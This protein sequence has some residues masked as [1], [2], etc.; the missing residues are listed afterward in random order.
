MTLEAP[1]PFHALD[2]GAALRALVEGTA[3]EIGEDFFI[4]LV[5]SLSEALRTDGAMV[6]EYLEEKRHLRALA[7]LM[8]GEWVPDYEFDITNTP[9]EAVITESRLLHVPENLLAMYPVDND[10]REAGLVSY[11]GV[12]LQDVDGHIL[13]HM[14]VVDRR[15]MPADPKAIALFRIFAA[16]AAAEMRRLRAEG[17]VRQREEKVRRLLDSAMDAILE[18]DPNLCVTQ[19]NSAAE[20]VFGCEAPDLL[21]RNFLELLSRE[22]GER[23]LHHV[24][25]IDAFPEGLRSTW[26]PG[27]LAA[28]RVG[29]TCFQAEATLSRFEV[30]RRP[31]HT[32][33]LRNVEDRLAAERRIH[34]LEDQ[35]EY[36]REEL[37]ALH[38]FEEIIGRSPALVSVLRDVEQVAETDST[39]L[40]LGETGVGKELIARAIHEASARR[41]KPLVKVN[42]AAVPANLIE[43]EFFG[44]EAGAFTGATRRR[45]GR[46]ALADKGSIFLDEVGELPLDL[47]AK[48]LRVLQEGEFE[49]VGSSITR[50]VDARILA[51][52]NR[53]LGQAVKQGA[54][55]EDLYYRLHVFPILIPPLRER[56]EDIPLLSEA[57]ARR[58][59]RRMGKPFAGLSLECI[60]ALSAYDWPGNVRELENV[61][62]RALITSR[63]GRL[64][65]D[66]ALPEAGATRREPPARIPEA[67]QIP[68]T[69]IL[70]EDDLRALERKNLIAALEQTGWKVSGPEGAAALLGM[71]P[72]TLTSRLKALGIRRPA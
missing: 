19:V 5:K 45:E 58:F 11:L 54:F 21:G 14:A 3:T 46:F 27:G 69:D 52:T 61:I 26:I 18:L 36:L 28:V 51:A 43:S 15:R 1:P 50:K 22:S 32:L 59:A 53:D 55:R 68:A 30:K 6:T 12:P 40:I 35:T 17:E 71:N 20:K 48:L 38:N 63:D 37:K 25:E 31:H 42:C 33:I 72:S 2:E 64:K 29:G 49:P 16:R 57:F 41:N 62:E 65:W 47:Q 8:D 9:C 7:F 13:G 34:N 66:R 44:H 23:L 60:R 67:S 56:R 70:T 10:L 24:K 39:V 4:S